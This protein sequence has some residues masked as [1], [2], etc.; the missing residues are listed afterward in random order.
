MKKMLLC[1]LLGPALVG[2]VPRY[3]VPE[4]APSARLRVVAQQYGRTAASVS[5]KPTCFTNDGRNLVVLA[6]LG[7]N[8]DWSWSGGE[9]NAEL[10]IPLRPDLLPAQT[11]ELHIEAGKPFAL[12]VGTQFP[13]GPYYVEECARMLVFTPQA[14]QDYEAVYAITQPRSACTLS[15]ARIESDGAGGFRRVEDT[16]FEPL[17]E[18]CP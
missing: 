4:G 16:A 10:G 2:C 8:A 18:L 14:G 15:L 11:S 12:R 1:A 7:A 5:S 3:A 13:S 9:K 17:T 6:G